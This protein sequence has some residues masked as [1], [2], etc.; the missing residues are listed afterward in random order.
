MS[1]RVFFPQ[2]ALDTW[3]VDGKVD[4]VQDELTILAEGRRYRLEESVRVVAEVTGAECPRG[5][6]GKVKSRAALQEL[7]AELMEQSMILGENA[8]DVVPGWTGAPIGAFE[9]HISSQARIAARSSRTNEA[10]P[11]TDE[12]LLAQFLLENM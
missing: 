5:L 9:E 11:A 3:M 7:G 6:V 4:M 8:Y 12:A 10:D 1:N 2:L